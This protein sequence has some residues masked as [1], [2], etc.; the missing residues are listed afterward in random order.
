MVRYF[1]NYEDLLENNIIN[2]NINIYSPNLY[3]KKRYKK[4]LVKF[5]IELVSISTF[6]E[7]IDFLNN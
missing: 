7:A 4:G 5:D 1:I 2:K 3:I 6:K